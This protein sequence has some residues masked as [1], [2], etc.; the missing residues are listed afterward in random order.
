MGGDFALCNSHLWTQVPS[1]VFLK[2]ESTEGSLHVIQGVH[3][4]GCCFRLDSLEAESEM[5]IFV[6]MVE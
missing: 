5:E 2:V 4:V 1:T 6:H 3:E